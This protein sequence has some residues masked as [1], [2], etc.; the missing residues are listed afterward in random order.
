MAYLHGKG[1]LHGDLC[2]G[3]I[4]LSASCRE[5]RGFTVKVADFGLARNLD[6]GQIMTETC[7]TVRV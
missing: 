4:L 3:N 6:A 5:E 1:I 2:G 7:G